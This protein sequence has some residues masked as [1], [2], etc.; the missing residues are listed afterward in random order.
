LT[1][2]QSEELELPTSNKIPNNISNNLNATDNL[3]E[4]FKCL[5][6]EWTRGNKVYKMLAIKLSLETIYNEFVALCGK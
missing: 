6:S 2:T 5:P 4:N 1:T 3:V